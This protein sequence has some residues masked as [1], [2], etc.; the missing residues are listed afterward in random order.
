M[1]TSTQHYCQRFQTVLVLAVTSISFTRSQKSKITSS[2]N[3]LKDTQYPRLLSTIMT[4]NTILRNLRGTL[5]GK[6]LI[7][8]VVHEQSHLQNAVTQ[9]G[10][11]CTSSSHLRAEKLS[12][13]VYPSMKRSKSV[14]DLIQLYDV[15]C[16]TFQSDLH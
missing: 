16:T 10:A 11:G 2:I 14:W 8:A 9:S 13:S 3:N 1:K 15:S 6:E 7:G 12:R 5:R 4:W